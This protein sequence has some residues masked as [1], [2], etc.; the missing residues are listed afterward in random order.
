M[1][2]VFLR[3]WS[4]LLVRPECRPV[5]FSMEI[6]STLEPTPCHAARAPQRNSQNLDSMGEGQGIQLQQDFSW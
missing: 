3:P 2:A 4:A 6:W 1:L 5:Q